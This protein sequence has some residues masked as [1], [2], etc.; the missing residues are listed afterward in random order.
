MG[1]IDLIILAVMAASVFV[2]MVQGF[3]R[4]ACSLLGLVLGVLLA[5]WNYA[6]LAALLRFG[7]KFEAFF[8]AIAF[9]LIAAAVMI[10]FNL[11]GILLKRLSHWLGLGFLDIVAGGVAGLLQG[12]LVVTVCL[13][14]TVA[15]FP[16]TTW[17]T[18]SRFPQLFFKTC[19]LDPHTSPEAL[20]AKVK[21][22]MRTLKHEMPRWTHEKN[23][24]S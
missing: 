16:Q 11:A 24:G 21:E 8:D 10:A 2:G 5:S 22:E 18:E 4:T 7:T 12:A 3:L 6:S 17:L 13:L 14:V 15:F 20:S 23:G 19:G 1:W 9:V